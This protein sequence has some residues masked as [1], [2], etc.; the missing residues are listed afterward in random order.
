[1]PS[2]ETNAR[3]AASAMS[4]CWSNGS[5][6]TSAANWWRLRR[7]PVRVLAHHV[8]QS[9]TAAVRRAVEPVG[10]RPAR[11][12]PRRRHQRNPF[13]ERP[14]DENRFADPG[15]AG[16]D[17]AALVRERLRL[18]VVD[19]PGD[20][21]RP[22]AEKPPVVA[23]IGGEEPRCPEGPA[24]VGPTADR[25]LARV[26]VVVGEQGVPAPEQ[27]AVRAGRNV[28][29]GRRRSDGGRAGRTAGSD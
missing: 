4:Q 14:G 2:S 3:G 11:A 10:A 28:R 9:L 8:G 20:P 7:E 13:V 1:M 12:A 24:P 27:L 23:G 22:P 29:V 21:P 19:H 15:M 16:R 5:R 18:Q 26:L 25:V 17:Q 6:S